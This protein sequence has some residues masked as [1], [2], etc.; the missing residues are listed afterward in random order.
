[1]RVEFALAP[2]NGLDERGVETVFARGGEDDFV[3]AGF[4]MC[5]PP[6]AGQEREQQNERKGKDEAGAQFHGP[7]VAAALA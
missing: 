2:D 6:L 7:T 3:L 5:A 1:M 4:K